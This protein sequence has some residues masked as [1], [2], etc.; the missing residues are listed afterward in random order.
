MIAYNSLANKTSPSGFRSPPHSSFVF[1]GSKLS[2]PITSLSPCPSFLCRNRTEI[3]TS[4]DLIVDG[5]PS[6][7]CHFGIHTKFSRVVNGVRRGSDRHEDDE[8][9]T[10]D[11]GVNIGGIH[12]RGE[13]E[14]FRIMYHHRPHTLG[15]KRQ[16]CHPAARFAIFSD[17][18][19]TYNNPHRVILLPVSFCV[20]IHQPPTEDDV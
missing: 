2:T 15:G 1:V 3:N 12:T 11:Y 13:E 9:D 19:S 18:H 8:D 14:T 4:D 17:S 7:S 6:T 10:D 5:Q 20:H 16:R